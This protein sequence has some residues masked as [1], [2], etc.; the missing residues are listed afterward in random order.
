MH[1]FLAECVSHIDIN[2]VNFCAGALKT[3]QSTNWRMNV[4]P[5]QDLV[6]SPT[7]KN[8]ECALETK[9]GIFL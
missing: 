4:V 9:G 8:K 1:I 5:E 2:K 3:T 7:T 6:S